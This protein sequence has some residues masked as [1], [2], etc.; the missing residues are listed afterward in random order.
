[1]PVPM[2]SHDLKSYVV[3]HFDYLDIMNAVV[4]LMMPCALFDADTSAN[5]IK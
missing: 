5:G 1:M 2:V 4:P 3:F